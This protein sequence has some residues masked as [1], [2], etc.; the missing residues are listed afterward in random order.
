MDSNE[1]IIRW[2][3]LGMSV[4]VWACSL[5]LYGGEWQTEVVDTS[6]AGTYSSF[7]LD[8]SGNGHV[9]YI[10]QGRNQ[11][12][13]GYWDHKL[14]KW[15]TTVVDGSAGYCS[16]AV[17]SK[18]R[19]HISYQAW[20]TGKIKYAYWDGSSWQKTTL[21]IQ[22]KEISF[23]TGIALDAQDQPRLSYYEYWGEGEDYE[24]HLRTVAWTGDRWEV[25]TI[26][27][28]PGS[29]KFNFLVSDSKGRPKIAY[30][31]VKAENQ[32]LRYAA[33]NGQ[34]WVIDVIEGADRPF[35]VFS[36]A[37]ALDGADNP[38]IV[39]TDV[40]HDLVK[41]AT[42]QHGKWELSV[43]DSLK[44]YGYPDR[45]GIACDGHGNPYVSYYDAGLGVLKVAHLQDGRW[46]PEVVADNFAGFTNSMQIR[47]GTIYLTFRD[48]TNQQLKFAFRRL[49]NGTG[50]GARHDNAG[51]A[52]SE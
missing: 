23:Y 26:D 7:R 32:S 13:Y 34:S 6:V 49:E 52:P 14:N 10:D 19:P 5:P 37:L 8:S 42:S 33:W 35:E 46:V 20:G 16:L 45:Y 4:V 30:A 3:W 51:S 15:F 24:L 40:A 31:N 17:D 48:D 29:G 36:V 11:V 9:C 2:H 41:Y 1:R 27:P 43:V 39:Y 21:L 38:H 22:A 12:K 44:D 25:E 50:V 18:D 28:T 47:G